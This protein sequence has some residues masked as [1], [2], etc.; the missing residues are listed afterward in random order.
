MNREPR[1]VHDAGA[2]MMVT[3]VASRNY[4]SLAAC[5]VAL[6]PLAIVVGR[7]GAGKSNFMDTMRFTA[8]A[9]QIS[10]DHALR[11]RGGIAEVC[12]RGVA[13]RSHFGIRLDF[14]LANALGWYAFD[15][16]VRDDGGYVVRREECLV[17]S[18]GDGV[19]QFF[20][21]ENG[22]CAAT[23]LTYP[24][25]VDSGALY[26]VRASSA[27]EFRP[28]YGAL[29]NM[30]FYQIDPRSLGG[31]QAPAGDRALSPDGSNAAGVLANMKSRRP[32]SVERLDDYL[33]A[34]DPEIAG[35]DSHTIGNRLALQFHRRVSGAARP[36]RYYADSMSDGTL[37]F[38]AV[39][40]ALL[41]GSGA[42]SDTHVVGIEE[43]EAALHPEGAGV[44]MDVLLEASEYTQV[45]VTTHSADLLDRELVPVKSILPV[46]SVDGESKIGPLDEVGSSV[47]RAGTFTAGELLRIDQLHPACE[48]SASQRVDLFCKA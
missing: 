31:L 26:L 25:L 10:V 11:E 2:E 16:G 6:G 39:L 18:S 37:H 5:D 24:P 41:H 44:L 4:K 22:R 9:L 42:G 35:V 46:V 33:A 43:P 30:L 27:P 38:L 13:Q 40:L 12:H 34:V 36:L 14:R 29:A 48:V 17:R 19:E 15:I 7:N 28:V 23:S 20:R 3:R 47:L 8:E 1:S 21:I 32:G 45:I